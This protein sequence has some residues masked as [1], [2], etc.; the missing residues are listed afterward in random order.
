MRASLFILVSLF[1]VKMTFADTIADKGK[2]NEADTT[3]QEHYDWFNADAQTDDIHGVSTEKAYNELLK[4]KESKTVIVA[5]IDSGIDIEHEDLQGKIWTNNDEIQGNGIDDDKNGYIDDIHGW[6]FIGGKD[7]K[8]VVH[9]TVEITRLYRKYKA[10]YENKDPK[11]LSKSENAGYLKYLEYKAAYEAE[12][13]EAETILGNIKS[14][15]DNYKIADGLVKAALEKESYTIEDLEGMNTN[16]DEMMSQVIGLM[17]YILEN[18]IKPED[19]E[20]GIEHYED[21]LKY[22]LDLEYNPREIVGD[23]PANLSNLFYGNNDVIGER[24]DHGTH[25]AGIIAANRNN[26]IGMRGIAENVKLMVL[27]VV[28]DG[29]ERDKD[30][31]NAIRYAVDNGARVINMS[32]GKDYSPNKAYVDKA[33]KYAESKKVLLIHASG[34]DALNNDKIEH[35]PTQKYDDGTKATN[36]ITVGASSK[37]DD[38]E[39]PGN[40]SNYGRKTVDIFAPGVDIYSLE[41]ENKYAVKSGTSMACPVVTGVAAL[42]MSYYPEFD[43]YQIKDI[44]LKSSAKYKRNKVYKPNKNGDKKKTTRFKKLSRTG[45]IVNAYYAIKMAG[46]LAGK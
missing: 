35:Y 11:T 42:L 38:L 20:E 39:L 10:K 32:F 40:F 16:G 2:R 9:E 12:Y 8:N 37:D 21:K 28:P 24:A 26:D 14:L 15:Y 13:S 44:L 45:G 22:N 23:D 27:R 25:V 46:E 30:V 34:N 1:I 31:A 3:S 4:G 5:I 43:I 41:P 29:D 7:G 6:N 19:L 17:T 36:W 33:V 18:D